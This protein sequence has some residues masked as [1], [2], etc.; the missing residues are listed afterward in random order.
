MFSLS[1]LAAGKRSPA[2]EGMDRSLDLREIQD[3]LRKVA[4]GSLI[5]ARRI[6]TPASATPRTIQRILRI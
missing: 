6:Q 4:M 5:R 1:A 2:L 3:S